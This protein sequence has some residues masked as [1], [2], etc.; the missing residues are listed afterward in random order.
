MENTGPVLGLDFFG[1]QQ[2]RKVDVR[3]DVLSPHYVSM[4]FKYTTPVVTTAI[5]LSGRPSI[6]WY[7]FVTIAKPNHDEFSLIVSKAGDWAPKQIKK[8]LTKIC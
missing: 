6:K 3:F 7:T 1:R 4:C 2:L 5:R 8:P